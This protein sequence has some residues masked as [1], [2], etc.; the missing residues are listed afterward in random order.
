MQSIAVDPPMVVAVGGIESPDN[1]CDV[2]PVAAGL[3]GAGVTRVRGYHG[4]HRL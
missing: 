4:V 3:A 2:G 1:P